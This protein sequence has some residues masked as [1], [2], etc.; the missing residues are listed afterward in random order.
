[1]GDN[2]MGIDGIVRRRG[3]LL[4]RRHRSSLLLTVYFIT[5]S[6]FNIGKQPQIK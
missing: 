5:L 4:N 6:I 2:G 3:A 1:M